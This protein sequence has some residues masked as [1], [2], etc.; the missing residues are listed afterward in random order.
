MWRTRPVSG[1]QH[2]SD[3][4]NRAGGTRSRYLK[5]K[6]REIILW[7]LSMRITLSAVH[8]SG[9][10]NVEAERLSRFQIENPHQLECSTEWSLNRR[11]TKLL[12]DI[13]VLPTADL[14]ATRLHNKVE[15]F[16]SRLPDPLAFQ[17]NSLQADW[18]K[19]LLHM[20]PPVSLLSHQGADSGHRDSTMVAGQRVVPPS[21]AA[22]SG[23]AS[24]VARA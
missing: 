1:G 19:G 21:P 5:W 3:A 2:H 24:D 17:D 15:A 6:V 12:F 20:Y 4:L 14:F 7:C 8:I 23:P 11:V 16:F 9:Q 10:D 18:S 13:W 22:P